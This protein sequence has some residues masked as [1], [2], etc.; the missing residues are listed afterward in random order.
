MDSWS[1]IELGVEDELFVAQEDVRDFFYRLGIDEELGR[2]FC[3][4]PVSVDELFIA[5]AAEGVSLEGVE[6][7]DREIWP[8]LAVLPMGFSWAF[9][10]AHVAHEHLAGSV[11][12]ETP[13][14]RDREP[15]IPLAQVSP[16]CL[17]YADNSNHLGTKHGPVESNRKLLSETLNAVGLLTHEVVPATKLAES[18]G[19]RI[20][21]LQK[22]VRATPSRDWTLHRALTAIVDG[23][24]VTGKELEVVIG[25]CTVRALLYRGLLSILNNVYSFIRRHYQQ[26]LPVWSSVMQEL[27][28]FRDLSVIGFAQLDLPWASGGWCTDACLTGCAVMAG[29]LKVEELAEVGRV[30][31][32]WRYR[33]LDGGAVAPRASAIL[34]LDTIDDVDSVL[35]SVEGEVLGEAVAVAGFPEIGDKALESGRWRLQFAARLSR[36]RKECTCVSVGVR[37]A[38][39]NIS[40]ATVY[41]TA[42]IM[43]YLWIACQTF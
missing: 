30:D 18:L 2:Y 17:I 16:Q 42:S 5:A 43:L 37:W 27:R 23:E 36:F 31:E 6:P 11:L 22:R 28:Q 4:P 19:V 38:L 40:V 9:H 1:R 3:L 15:S 20:N 29:N 24:K 33:R 25:H 12:G 7:G 21:G 13:L 10:L 34:D 8:H 32:R 14:V 39:Q 35:P 41:H 26:R